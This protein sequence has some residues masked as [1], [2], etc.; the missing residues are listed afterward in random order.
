VYVLAIIADSELKL[1][2]FIYKKQVAATQLKN[3]YTSLW[4][5][6]GRRYA[7]QK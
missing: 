6:T 4:L 5:Q 3:K 1:N 7:A 2:N